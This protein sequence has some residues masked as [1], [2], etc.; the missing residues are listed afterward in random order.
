MNQLDIKRTH[1]ESPL[2]RIAIA[3][4]VLLATSL[5]AAAQTLITTVTAG[6]YP[7]AIAVNPTTNKIY[8]VNQNSNNLT[9]IDG[10]TYRTNTVLTGNVPNA[11][12]VNAVTNKIYVVNWASASVTVVDGAT[13]RTTTVSA[14]DHPFA[15]AVNTVT[16]KIYVANYSSNNVTVIDGAT[17]RTT[18]TSAGGNPFALAV[19]ATTNKIYVADSGS[20]DVAIIDGATNRTTMVAAGIYPRAVAIDPFANRIYVANYDSGNVSVI[21][22]A[23]NLVT[24]VAAGTYPTAVSINPITGQAYVTNSGSGTATVIDET[25]LATTTVVTGSSPTAI[26]IDLLTNKAYLTNNIWQGTVTMIDGANDSTASVSLGSGT[27]PS[28]IVVNPLTNVVYVAN[29]V[30][31]SVSIIAG[32]SS[33]A[34]QFLPVTPCRVADT[35]QADGPFGGPYLTA[36]TARSFAVPQ[37]SCNVPST[38]IAYSLNVTVAPLQSALE[39]LTIWPTGLPQPVVSTLNSLDGRVKANAAIV[40]AGAGGAVSVYAT[41]STHVILDINGYFQPPADSTLQFSPLAPCR[42]VDTRNAQGELGGPSLQGGQERDFPVLSSDCQI[43]SSAQAYSMNFTVV[44]VGG[45]PL[46]YL[47]VWPAGQNQPVVSTLNNPTATIVANAAI[48]PSGNG[49]AIAVYPD[50]D[51]HL[52]VDINGYFAAPAPGGLSLYPAAPCRVLDTRSTGGA[53]SGQR[54][55]PVN[56]SA[57]AC[58]LPIT[59]Q[60]YIFNATVIPAGSLGYLTLWAD[61]ERQPTAST[62]NGQDGAVTSNM[63]IVGNQDGKINAYAYG[64]TQL[65]MDISSYFAP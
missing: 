57:S 27:W 3:F 13:N 19:N 39:Y 26:D 50:Q 18:T 16:N 54:N 1:A 4:L 8:V 35:R 36:G 45:Q 5:S 17:D 7:V 28:A 31:D 22:G 46:G 55:P 61:G 47:T 30:A 48:V 20:N 2:Q 63:A 34:V 53:F 42:V 9:V 25:T 59:A 58:N 10:A 64:V 29:P 60:G 12:A 51:T 44:P 37:S 38:A 14:G 62:L 32:A 65:L 40:P 6:T 43:P 33:G 23:T 56:V 24:T 11:V 15:V 49:G 21:D 52:I 41:D